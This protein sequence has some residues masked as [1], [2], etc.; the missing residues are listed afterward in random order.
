[1]KLRFFHL[2]VMAALFMGYQIWKNA[3]IPDELTGV[4]TTA[5]PDYAYSAI[6]FTH[7]M[8][9]F[10]REDSRVDQNTIFHVKKSDEKGKTLYTVRYVSAEGADYTLDIYYDAGP[11][12]KCLRLKNQPDIV[13]IKQKAQ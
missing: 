2:F 11:P 1:M 13:W 5:D 10:Q 9:K 7:D 4:W 3:V 8:V 12:N 6:E